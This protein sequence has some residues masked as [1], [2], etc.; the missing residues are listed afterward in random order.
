MEYRSANH[1]L[2]GQEVSQVVSI[3]GLVS[4]SPPHFLGFFIG[5]RARGPSLNRATTA[6]SL[7]SASLLFTGVFLLRDLLGPYCAM[8]VSF[9]SSVFSMSLILLLKRR[10]LGSRLNQGLFG[11]SL[12]SSLP[13]STSV[14]AISTAELL[15]SCGWKS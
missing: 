3:L 15:L 6:S 11:E 9:A 1:L 14:E 2:L 4:A 13:E 5:G 7:N 12:P 10:L 8:V